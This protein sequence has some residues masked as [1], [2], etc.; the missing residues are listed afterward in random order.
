[1]LTIKEFCNRYGLSRAT[2]YRLRQR[3]QAPVIVELTR[4]RRAIRLADAEAWAE[5]LRHA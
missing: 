3:G 2:L 4:R 5:G 1:M